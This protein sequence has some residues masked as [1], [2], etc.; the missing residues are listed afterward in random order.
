LD[1]YL[2]VVMS[3]FATMAPV[4]FCD[5]V[6]FVVMKVGSGAIDETDGPIDE[7]DGPNV[8]D[9]ARTTGPVRGGATWHNPCR[10]CVPAGHMHISLTGNVDL[11]PAPTF[12]VRRVLLRGGVIV[13]RAL[14]SAGS[15]DRPF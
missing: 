8:V 15:R 14:E 1:F 13:R 6:L 12:F 11:A 7:T 3:L 4:M 2:F 9:A 5:V 10:V